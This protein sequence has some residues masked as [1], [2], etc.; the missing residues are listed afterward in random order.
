M[1]ILTTRLDKQKYPFGKEEEAEKTGSGK[2]EQAEGQTEQ[3]KKRQ[4]QETVYRILL[5]PIIS[6]KHLKCEVLNRQPFV[7]EDFE[8]CINGAKTTGHVKNASLNVPGGVGAVLFFLL[9]VKSEFREIVIA[10]YEIGWLIERR[11]YKINII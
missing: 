10:E 6:E 4:M 11:D 8:S 5:M 3:K 9:V 7:F 2:E 1:E